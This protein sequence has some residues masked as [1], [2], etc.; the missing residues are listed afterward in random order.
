MGNKFSLSRLRKL[1]ESKAVPLIATDTIIT[2]QNAIHNGT[3]IFND[4]VTFNANVFGLTIT[5]SIESASYAATASYAISASQALTA[6][7][8]SG[9]NQNNYVLVNDFNNYTSSVSTYYGTNNAINIGPIQASGSSQAT[10]AVLPTGSYI[11]RCT[12][13]NNIK[14]FVLSSGH[15]A[16]LGMSFII[17]NDDATNNTFHLYPPVNGKINDGVVNASLLIDRGRSVMLIC[18][19]TGSSP[20]WG[21]LG[22]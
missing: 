6:S 9:F 13:D 10:A 16:Y 14:S 21:A 7:N 3:T 20:K 17:I 4:D 5:G 15:S 22:F 11:Y 2:E 12:S 18:F 8:L 1:L 19:D